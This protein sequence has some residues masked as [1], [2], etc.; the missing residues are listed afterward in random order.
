VLKGRKGLPD[1]IWEVPRQRHGG[2]RARKGP[3]ALRRGEALKG[4]AQERDRHETR[5]EGVG[6]SKPS[7]GRE[8]LKTEGVG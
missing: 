1:T 6:R 7:G 4:K 5:P 8:T 2:D 3:K